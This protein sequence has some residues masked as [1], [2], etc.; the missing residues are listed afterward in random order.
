MDARAQSFDA[1]FRRDV[2]YV[3]PVFQRRYAWERERQWAPLWDDVLEVVTAYVEAAKARGGSPPSDDVPVHFLGAIVVKL[4]PFGAGQLE[5]REIIDGQQ[6]LTTIQLMIGAAARALKDLGGGEQAEVLGDLIRNRPYLTKG[7][8][9][10]IFKVWPTK[11]DRDAFRAVMGAAEVDTAMERHRVVEGFRFF[12]GAVRDWANSIPDDER[13][14][15]F[16]AFEA[17][18][19][20]QLRIVW[21]D[22][23]E[24]DNAQV[25]FETL[26]DRGA[27]L[28]AIDL[29]KNLVFQRQ[30]GG[31]AEELYEQHWT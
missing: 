28:N 17:I 13:D 12:E 16:Q 10:S 30:H 7:E 29:V 26:N 20:S 4:V 6:R 8:P 21:I 22:L 24:R 2:R 3:V 15:H 27:P 5:L 1:I 18:V 19:R 23:E 14:L 31:E 25:I 11:H 9:D